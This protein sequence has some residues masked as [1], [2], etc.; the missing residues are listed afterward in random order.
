MSSKP[1]TRKTTTKNIR[2]PY[3]LLE[4]IEYAMQQEKTRNLSAWIREACR[5]RLVS[6]KSEIKG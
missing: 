1:C 2:F 4:Q 5:A 3:I 6:L